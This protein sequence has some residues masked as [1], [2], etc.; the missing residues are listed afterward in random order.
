MR[1]FSAVLCQHAPSLRTLQLAS[2]DIGLTHTLCQSNQEA[3]ELVLG[4]HCAA[5]IV[6]FDQP[7]ASEVIK[8][9]SLLIPPLRPLLLALSGEWLGGAGQAFQSGVSRIL[10]KPLQ[11]E[12]VRDALDATRPSKKKSR[13]RAPRFELRSLAYLETE[14]G[15]VPAIGLNIS[16]QGM[17]LRT[18]EPIQPRPDVSFRCILPG[19]RAV[20]HGHADIIWADA[21]GRAGIFFSRLSPSARKHLKDW[22]RQNSR[23]NVNSTRSLLPPAD[24]AVFSTP[25]N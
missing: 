20:L 13:Q 12:Q 21:Q 3:M 7:G 22:L 5:L 23:P 15:S 24:S 4:G 18:A 9:A 14:T 8:T 16:E 11:L 17:A 6:D 1:R 10:Y 25:R 2:S 19:S